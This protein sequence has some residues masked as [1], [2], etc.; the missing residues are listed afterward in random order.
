ME[1]LDNVMGRL[2]KRLE[3]AQSQRIAGKEICNKCNHERIIVEKFIEGKWQAWDY[4]KSCED[5]QKGKETVVDY[6][7]MKKRQAA[8]N[9]ALYSTMNEDQIAAT[10][11][12][13]EPENLTQQKALAACKNLYEDLLLQKKPKGILLAG[14]YGIGKSHLAAA[15]CNALA[16]RAKSAAFISISQLK[17]KLTSTFNNGSN[18]T[19]D[20]IMDYLRKVDLLVIDDIGQHKESEFI[21]ETLQDLLNSRQGKANIYTT[22]L[23][24]RD[25]VESLNP[26][27]FERI[28]KD[29]LP[30][31]VEGESRRKFSL[32][33]EWDF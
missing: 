20:E 19:A 29:T 33:T 22:N 28:K 12:N 8:D 5:L 18:I 23:S 11:E 26:R 2:A 10:F 4:C 7:A 16:A 9:L 6:L 1:A 27:V 21:D 24:G 3:K 32:D 17:R 30:I 13:F 14:S 31:K 15:I 25:L